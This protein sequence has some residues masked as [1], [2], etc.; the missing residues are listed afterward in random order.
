MADSKGIQ[1]PVSALP[2]DFQ[3]AMKQA[4]DEGTKS[5]QQLARA[6]TE[7]AAAGE[8]HS[9][10]LS[11]LERGVLKGSTA[12]QRTAIELAK[13]QAIRV[14]D[15]EAIKLQELAIANLNKVMADQ[16]RR[17]QEN[18]GRSISKLFDELRESLKP[19]HPELKKLQDEEAKLTGI[20]AKL[21]AEVDE[22]TK[23]TIEYKTSQ[24]ELEKKLADV[25]GE[26]AKHGTA[27]AGVARGMQEIKKELG[28]LPGPMGTFQRGLVSS[29]RMSEQG[30]MS[31][32]MMI[33]TVT[34]MGS[35][36]IAAGGGLAYLGNKAYE[37]IDGITDLSERYGINAIE[38]SKVRYASTQ[39]DVTLDQL[40]T[41][42][43]FFSKAL[44]EAQDPT[45]KQ[46]KLFNLLKVETTDADG[47]IRSFA[48]LL[49]VMAD[50][51]GQLQTDTE[52]VAL[53]QHVFGKVGTD[54]LPILNQGADGLQKLIDKNKEL[55]LELTDHAIKAAGD[56][57][58]ASKDLGLQLTA[59]SET[60]GIAVL[61]AMTRFTKWANTLTYSL[62][63]PLR[64]AAAETADACADVADSA[65]EAVDGASDLGNMADQARI[66]VQNLGKALAEGKPKT[67]GATEASKKHTKALDDQKKKAKE[68]AEAVAKVTGDRAVDDAKMADDLMAQQDRDL[69]TWKKFQAE[70]YGLNLTKLQ[71]I[72]ADE[73]HR[74]EEA[75]RLAG[76]LFD[77]EAELQEATTEIHK[78]AAEE[79][80][81]I[82]KEEADALDEARVKRR[83][84]FAATSSFMVGMANDAAQASA[85]LATA[86]SEQGLVSA[87]KAAK[88]AKGMAVFQAVLAI[89]LAAA[90]A[91]ASPA[92]Q[93]TTPAGAAI[94][95]G[96]AAGIAAINAAAVIAT[97]LPKYERGG[98]VPGPRHANGGVVSELEGGENIFSRK[99][100]RNAGGQR[101]LE[102]MK[103][104]RGSGSDASFI[105][106]VDGKRF[107]QVLTSQAASNQEF[108]KVIKNRKPVGIT[109]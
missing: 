60:I 84:Q 52:R 91:F 40:A 6:Q 12:W 77:S 27:S 11:I 104:G 17:A 47:K 1:I 61:P 75:R 4:M 31:L 48:D 37:T 87:E 41:G 34:L 103:R 86:L 90:N 58:Q 28:T 54:L 71:K 100:V 74:V 46:A 79:R 39:L 63:E 57:E 89:P 13:V 80:V 24:V 38:L 102:G 51:F 64:K 99:D 66:D 18:K 44:V 98:P 67:E 85:A 78:A 105:L 62:G 92:A 96:I 70:V 59:L 109:R 15:A 95:A 53:A 32:G 73:Q 20:Q 14:T 101:Q 50:R 45:S 94:I 25:R 69:E 88:F 49:P 35:A 7:A 93:A 22:A 23:E 42:S 33:G 43:K 5:V 76:E 36:A 8:K 30:S 2:D 55:S 106:E 72:D 97:P 81:K 108:R 3:A 56:Y 19:I 16:I 65:V 68:A 9:K 21:A 83:Q 29:G 82:S 10:E 26:M 107:G